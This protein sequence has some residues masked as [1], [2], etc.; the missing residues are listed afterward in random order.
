[1]DFGSPRK[2]GCPDPDHAPGV[3][4]VIKRGVHLAQTGQVSG[5]CTAPI[6]KAALIESGKD[7]AYVMGWEEKSEHLNNSLQQTLFTTLE[8]DEFE[9]VKVLKSND[10]LGIDG[11]HQKIEMSPGALS[12]ILLTLEFKGLIKSLPGKRYTLV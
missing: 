7:I 1:M 10:N 4:E 5:L 8:G 12:S 3:I 6:H 11:L 9:V 2:P